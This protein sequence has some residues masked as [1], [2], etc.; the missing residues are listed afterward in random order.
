MARLLEELSIEEKAGL[1]MDVLSKKNGELLSDWADLVDEYDLEISGDTLRKA[2]VGVKLAYDAGMIGTQ[3]VPPDDGVEYIERQKMRD[4]VRENNKVYRA[5]ARD[6]LL[7]E[8]VQDAVKRAGIFSGAFADRGDRTDLVLSPSGSMVV[9]LG[10]IHF[11]EYMDVRGFV[12]EVINHYDDQV[13]KARL[14]KLLHRIKDIYQRER[15]K[16]I[17]VMLVGDCIA[18]MLRMSQLQ[19]LQYGIVDATIL[20]SE[21][22]AE[23]IKEIADGTGAHVT[24]HLVGGNHDEVRPLG[25]KAGDFPK[26]N[27]IKIIHW[28]LEEKFG[29]YS[30]WVAISPLTGRYHYVSIEGYDFL[31][32][33]GD[34]GKI[35]DLSRDAVNVYGHHVDYFVCGHLHHEEEIASGTTKDGNSVIIRVPSLCGMDGYAQK[36]GRFSRPGAT[37]LI[38]QQ[39]MGRRCVYPIDLGD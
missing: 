34:G 29:G 10:D 36:L 35:E 5:T 8:A 11:G 3:N 24:V 22:L 31:M 23:W 17:H 7:R 30:A 37:V 13:C 2:G 18:G 25:S 14:N 15:V 20:F 21:L 27:V 38:M 12:G 26:D 6:E 33:H 19:N 9:A 16:D 39:G 32:L 1:V 4:L 28:Y